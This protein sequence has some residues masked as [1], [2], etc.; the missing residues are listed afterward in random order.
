MVSVIQL[1]PVREGGPSV[2]PELVLCSGPHDP[3]YNKIE[4]HCGH[5]TP[6]PKTSLDFEQDVIITNT[7]G[8]LAVEASDDLE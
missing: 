5:N 3:V 2:A 4:K 1:F 6:L 8:K 7:T